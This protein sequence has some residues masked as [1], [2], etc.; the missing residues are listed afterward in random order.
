MV[1]F[2]TIASLFSGIAFAWLPQDRDLF[3]FNASRFDGQE[4]FKETSDGSRGFERRFK[5]SLPNG[6]TKIRGV[7]FGGKL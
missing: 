3:A 4:S 5:P 1:S 2:I 6:V 7:N